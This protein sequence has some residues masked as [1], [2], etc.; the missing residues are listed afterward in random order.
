MME[1]VKNL[2]IDREEDIVK[3]LPPIIGAVGAALIMGIFTGIKEG[4]KKGI[5]EAKDEKASRSKEK[6]PNKKKESKKKDKEI[7]TFP[8]KDGSIDLENL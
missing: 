6:R 8:M 2:I 1:R 7:K 5:E 4:V 3:E